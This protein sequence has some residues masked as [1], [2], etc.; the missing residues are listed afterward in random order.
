MANKYLDEMNRL[1]MQSFE[2]NYAK[3]QSLS[4]REKQVAKLNR[5]EALRS[6]S[7]SYQNMINPYSTNAE[8]LAMRGLSN[9]GIVG[10]N[11]ARLYG[12]YQNN[13]AGANDA[14]NNSLN[15]ISASLL[16]ERSNVNAKKMAQMAQY[17]ERLY[18]DYWARE[19]FD[20]EKEND[21]KNYD[22]NQAKFDYEKNRDKISDERW[23]EEFDFRKAS[24]LLKNTSSSRRSTSLGG[25]SKTEK[26]VK[27]GL[28]KNKAP[29]SSVSGRV[30]PFKNPLDEDEVLEKIWKLINDATKKEDA[31]W[32]MEFA[33]R[34]K[35][36]TSEYVDMFAM[37]QYKKLV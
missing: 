21:L 20:Y 23:Q 12:N 36:P 17:Y 11:Y 31:K 19:K 4:D 16:S 2:E 33:K 35:V 25:S 1:L 13:V 8:S 26:G 9:S 18:D 30:L 37:L 5:D 7:I 6:S 34:A 15:D 32:I 27:T 28:G 29:V 14:Y 3:Y 10:S 24:S 22:F